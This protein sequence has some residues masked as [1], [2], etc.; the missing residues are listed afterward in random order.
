MKGLIFTTD[1]LLAVLILSIILG[2]YVYVKSKLHTDNFS[3]LYTSKIT[4]DVLI[5]LTKNNTLSTFNQN[6]ISNVLTQILP[7]NVG[8]YLRVQSFQC[9]NV[10]CN[11][12]SLSN[13]FLIDSCTGKSAELAPAVSRTTFLSFNNKKIQ[14]FGLAELRVCLV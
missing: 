1:A 5:V 3:N 9:A 13:E 12:F 11:S 4:N 6:L 8:A 10:Q 7:P 14:N 2:G